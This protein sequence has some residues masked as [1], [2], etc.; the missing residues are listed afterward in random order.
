VVPLNE[1]ALIDEAAVALGQDLGV[2]MERA[3]EALA[4][5]AAR[6]APS[7]RI[8]VVCGP[9]NNGGD[10]YVCARLLAEAGR[11]VT[12]WAVIAP[13]SPLC[14]RH[15]K[16]LPESVARVTTVPSQAPALV[17]DAILGAGTRGKPREPIAGALA[18]LKQLAAPVLA[19]D[20]P[21][22]LGTDLM[23]PATLT[24]CLQVAKQELMR[25]RG[26]G[27]FKTVDIGVLPAAFQEVQPTCLRRFPPLKRT[28]HKGTHGELLVI[29]GGVFPG[30]LEFACRAAV[31]TGCDMVR[32]WTAEGPPLPPGIIVHRH[33]GQALQPADPEQ[34]TPMLVRASAVL[35]GPGLGR[36]AGGA[37]AAQQALS[38]ALEMGVPAVLDADALT[39]CAPM[40]RELPEGESRLLLTPHRTEARNLMSRPATEEAL[41][42][43]ARPDRVML[44]KAPVDLV[45]DGWRWQRNPRGNPRMAVGGTGDILAGLA[46]GLMARGA[47]PFDAARMAVLWETT[48]A[49]GLWLEQG[50]CYDAESVL[51]RLP[52]TLRSFL[53]PLG[54][55]PPVVG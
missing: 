55:W 25:G 9:G 40:V 54:S 45:T 18:A 46:A 39:H 51:T 38:L 30:A 2:L 35:I 28:G 8:L 50:P 49:D 47:L 1:S 20:I 26:L 6:M 21:S 13:R 31:M 14:E 29:G 53:E 27:E 42:E 37:E 24:V 41:H 5:E 11:D 34:L 17:V 16:R 19:S 4:R 48:A 15:A 23:L 44:A 3:G 7:G 43:F 52:A 12:V 22:G 33:P 10:G 36:E 32:A